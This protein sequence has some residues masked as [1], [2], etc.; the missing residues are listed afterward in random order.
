[1][2]KKRTQQMNAEEINND[3]DDL[4]TNLKDLYPKLVNQEERLERAR[5]RKADVV[6]VLYELSIL[7]WK[8]MITAK[9]ITISMTV[10]MAA[11]VIIALET[12]KFTLFLIGAEFLIIMLI[13]YIWLKD[14][15]DYNYKIVNKRDESEQLDRDIRTAKAVIDHLE[16]R[17]KEIQGGLKLRHYELSQIESPLVND[18]QEE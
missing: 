5:H 2:Q 4:N 16:T 15:A 7:T 6:G 17:E 3:I 1:M 8:N 14:K 18:T 13:D 10:V 9:W 12:G 11:I